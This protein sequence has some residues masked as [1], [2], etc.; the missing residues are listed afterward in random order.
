MQNTYYCQLQLKESE[1]THVLSQI[2][3]YSG[4]SVLPNEFL[5]LTLLFHMHNYR[6]SPFRV[7]TMRSWLLKQL[8]IIIASGLQTQVKIKWCSGQKTT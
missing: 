8:L 1:H 3:R 5:A 2:P 7:M 6:Q 4:F